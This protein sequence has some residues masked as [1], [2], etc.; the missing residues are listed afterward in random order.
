M[1]KRHVLYNHLFLLYEVFKEQKNSFLKLNLQIFSHSDFLSAHKTCEVYF[2]NAYMSNITFNT[3]KK[4]YE[5][6]GAGCG[7]SD[8]N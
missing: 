5:E 1:T 4:K 6:S 2:G 8:G 7:F 3:A